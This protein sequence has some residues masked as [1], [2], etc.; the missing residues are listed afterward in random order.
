MDEDFL[1]DFFYMPRRQ[2]PQTIA[3]RDYLAGQAL[4]GL[5]INPSTVTPEVPIT[6]R[7]Y[8]LADAMLSSRK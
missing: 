6:K 8:E 2:K 4:T 3:L 7:A 1:R 5:I